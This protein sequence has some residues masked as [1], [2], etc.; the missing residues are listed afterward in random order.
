VVGLDV[1]DLEFRRRV[2]GGLGLPGDVQRLVY[3]GLATAREMRQY[4]G[5]RGLMGK[6]WK[7]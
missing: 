7:F 4:E 3:V 5:Y 1:Q 2:A 6:F